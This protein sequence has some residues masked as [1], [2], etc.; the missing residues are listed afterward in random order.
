[1]LL[2]ELRQLGTCRVLPLTDAIP[3][4]EAIEPTRNYLGFEVM[5]TTSEPRGAI[6]DVFIFVA[7][8]CGLGIEAVVDDGALEPLGPED[9]ERPRPGEAASRARRGRAGA[10]RPGVGG[11]AAGRRRCEP[12]AVKQ[13]S[14]GS[15]RSSRCASRPSRRPSGCRRCGSMR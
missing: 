5:L 4:L 15:R 8:D 3:P 11:Q 6:E 7:D 1:M 12:D 13:D 14:A 2:D 9:E 10:P